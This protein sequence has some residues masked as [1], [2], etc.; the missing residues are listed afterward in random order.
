MGGEIHIG[1]ESYPAGRINE[2]ASYGLSKSFRGLG[3]DLGRMRTGTPPRLEKSSID[4][5]NLQIQESDFPAIPFSYMN[6][7]VEQTVAFYLLVEIH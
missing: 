6:S 3:L 7:T 1:S 5:S 2:K 4:F